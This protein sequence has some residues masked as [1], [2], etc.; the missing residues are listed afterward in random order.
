VDAEPDDPVEVRRNIL[1]KGRLHPFPH[2][3]NKEREQRKVENEEDES[4]EHVLGCH[5]NA[6]AGGGNLIN[7]TKSV[8]L[9]PLP[10]NEPPLVTPAFTAANLYISYLESYIKLSLAVFRRNADVQP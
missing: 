8:K 6:V 1:V 2:S 4:S 7:I 9:N 10:Q 3:K 5:C